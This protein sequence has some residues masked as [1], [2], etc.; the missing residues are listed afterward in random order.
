MVAS[1]LE[2]RSPSSGIPN[3]AGSG[4]VATTVRLSD[5]ARAGLRFDASAYGLE[6][7]AAVAVLEAGAFP[8]RPLYG[9]D[10]VCQEAHNAFRF[11]RVY[12]E[13]EHGVPFLSS[14]DIISM[15]P[16]I[17]NYLSR[18]LTKNLDRLIVRKW[19][20][21]VSCSGTVGN[22]GLVGDTLAGMA[23]SQHAIRLR[24]PD[25]ETSGF[26][27][28]FLRSRYGRPQL[29]GA[30]YGSVVVHIEP[31]QLTRVQVP[32]IPALRRIALGRQMCDATAMRDQANVLLANAERLLEH[33]LSLPPLTE[34]TP[35]RS[36]SAGN[37]VRASKLSGRFDAAYHDQLTGKI[38]EA[39]AALPIKVASVGDARVTREVRAITKFRKRVYT[40]GGGL[41]LINTRQLFQV[42]PVEVKR[43]ARGAHTKDLPEIALVENMIAAVR[44]GGDS[45]GRIQIIPAY[46]NGW[47]GSEHATRIIATDERNP[48]YL[49][50]WLASEYGQR[51]IRRHRYGS[52]I[53]EI[54]KEMFRSVPVPLPP[55]TIENEIGDLVL[56]ANRLR[57]TAWRT[58]TETIALLESLVESG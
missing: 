9:V 27:A 47:C 18:K 39:I 31:E 40:R 21:L 8:L 2:K 10:A 51:L 13:P 48:G 58:E 41:P 55:A 49:Y 35:I 46:M 15:R 24:S 43:L 25:A 26:V 53:L 33:Y 6:A 36:R 4:H 52:V 1:A 28:A 54:D 22:V 34:L 42:D 17:S 11:Q 5:V 45:I 29:R 16:E 38:E 37:A 57:D 56:K 19:D 3:E 23:L 20:V 50:A 32:E 30:S 14:S 12:V 44:S 7:R